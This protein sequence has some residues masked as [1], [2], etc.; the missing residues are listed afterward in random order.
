MLHLS[1]A[2]RG[3][4]RS[5]RVRGMERF[6]SRARSL[7]LAQTGAEDLLWRKLR[8]RQLA[9][10]KFRRQHPIDRFIVDF[11]TLD[12]K[13]IVEIDVATHSEAFERRRDAHRTRVLESLGFH[14]LRVTNAD[15]Y[16]NLEGVLD[17]I[18][19]ELGSI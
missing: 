19:H 16:D 15:V 3:R 2:G 5:G 6:K 14:V 4:P 12:G 17:G 13:L 9:R 11:I 7:R 8:G 18:L 1:P 10:W